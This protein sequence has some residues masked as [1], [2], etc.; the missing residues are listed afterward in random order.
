MNVYKVIKQML[1]KKD[2]KRMNT[3]LSHDELVYAYVKAWNKLDVSII[4]PLLS[5]EF[6]YGS[7]W[8][9]EELH[10]KAAYMDYISGKFSAI[11]KS[12][13][14]VEAKIGIS[15]QTGLSRVEMFQDGQRGAKID[16]KSENGKMTSA[17]MHDL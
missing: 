3:Q 5:D 7:M 1:T 17:Y 10:G 4:E 11:K 9:F 13:S 12:G 8:V 16:V 14:V 2:S 6:T 15:P